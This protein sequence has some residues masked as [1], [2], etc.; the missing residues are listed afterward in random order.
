MLLA[1]AGYQVLLLDR[2]RFPRDTLSTLYIH[3]PG[4]AQLKRWGVLDAVL[5]TGCPPVD[6]AVHQVADVR[7][8]GSCWPIDGIRAAYAPRRY[9]L[10]Q[11]LIEAAVAAGVEFR[12]G[13]AVEDVVF[14][15][16]RV[17]GVRCR[18]RGRTVEERSRL[19]IGA[20]GMRSRIADRV[21]AAIITEQP[22]MTCVYY[23][24][25]ADVPACFEAYGT[26]DRWTGSVPTNDDL[27]LVV[28]Y[29][30]Q[31]EFTAVRA[32]AGRSY[33]DSVRDIAPD[34]YQRVEAGTQVDRLYGC[35]EQ[36]NFLRQPA[37]PGWALVG[38]AGHHKDSI[39]ARGIT[40]AFRQA[41]ALVNCIGE[42]LRDQ[43]RLEAALHRYARER[44]ELVLD[45]YQDTLSVAALRPLRRLNLLRLISADPM[46]TERFFATIAGANPT[47]KLMTAELRAQAHA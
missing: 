6:R 40:D 9:L 4:I 38:D 39:T 23:S 15:D 2:A 29:F 25:W 8:E 14:T 20:D 13:C 30:P 42:D 18:Y 31:S 19:V 44:N 36:R 12:D 24:F 27:T 37:G 47:S 35:G 5:A 11:I 43:V 34:L 16:G 21:G 32:D 45:G 26:T 3:Q 10:D 22:P 17:T 41:S 33:L 46:L 28:S 7:I 1:R